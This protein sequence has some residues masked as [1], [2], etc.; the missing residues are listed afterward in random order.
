MVPPLVEKEETAANNT[1]LNST[2]QT[3]YVT[4]RIYIVGIRRNIQEIK[5]YE[6]E[7]SKCCPETSHCHPQSVQA[8]ISCKSLHSTGNQYMQN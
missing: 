2:K 8:Q 4:E 3:Q 7:T 1:D 6:S 5:I